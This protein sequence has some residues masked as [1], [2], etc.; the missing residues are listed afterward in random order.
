MG[1]PLHVDHLVAIGLLDKATTR[2]SSSGSAKAQAP[3][4]SSENKS[5]TDKKNASAKGDGAS[6]APAVT[7]KT[8]ALQNKS[9]SPA[10]AE[11]GGGQ[12]TDLGT[13]T[14]VVAGGHKATF[15]VTMVRNCKDNNGLVWHD[16]GFEDGSASDFVKPGKSVRTDMS[17]DMPARILNARIHTAGHLI[18][19]A[20][21]AVG[22]KSWRP[23]KGYHF[24]DGPY[25]E[26]IFP[27]EEKDE[28]T[29]TKDS[30]RQSI[31][32][33]CAELIRTN[34]GENNDKGIKS[35]IKNGVRHISTCGIETHCGGTHVDALEKIGKILVGKIELKKD[36]AR[37]KYKLQGA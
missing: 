29:K 8:K 35:E 4:N 2:P 18:D 17:V 11:T 36:R 25:V 37:V 31:E 24:P 5:V 19:A 32:D 15:S 30:V 6:P 26:Y 22:M 28:I 1:A 13:I 21:S 7:K 34:A 14:I 27:M 12:P 23:A 3:L 10:G 20:V 9:S 33:A 16:G